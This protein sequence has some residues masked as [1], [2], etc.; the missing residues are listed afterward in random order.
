MA[1]KL[2]KI[3]Y[4]INLKLANEINNKHLKIEY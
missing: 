3:N 4:T 1:N 2:N